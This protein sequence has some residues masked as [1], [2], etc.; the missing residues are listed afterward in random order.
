VTPLTP[1][2]EQALLDLSGVC[3]IY[4]N[5][6]AVVRAL[7]G[8]SL[9]VHAGEFVAIMGQSGSGKSTLMNIIGCL[10]RP[11]SGRYRVAGRDVSRLSPDELAALRSRMFG[12]VFQR[13]NLLGTATAVENVE[14]PGVYAGRRRRDRVVRATALLKRLGLGDRIGHR[15]SE[16]SG[17]QQQR[18]SIARALMN[19]AQIILADEPTGALDSKS[20]ED[21]L[22]LLHELHD[23]GRTIVLIT[24]DPAIAAH[25]ERVIQIRDGGIVSDT[26]AVLRP[27]ISVPRAPAS[28]GRHSAPLADIAEATKTA[29]RALRAN[30]FRT[31]LTLLGVVIGVAAVVV[32]LAIGNGS[33]QQVLDRI[34]AM[35]TNLLIVRPGAPGVRSSGDTATLVPADAE[36]IAALPNVEAAVPER[37][38]RIT[39]RVGNIDYQT[40]ILGTS[41]QYTNTRGWDVA[42]G[43]FITVDDVR[44]Y[45]PVIVLGQTVARNLF[46]DGDDPVGRYV[47]VRNVPMQVVGV[48]AP[49]G[50]TPFGNDQDDIAVVPLTTGFVQLFGHQYL[51]TVSVKVTDV[52]QIDQT[53]SAIDDLLQGRH[54]TLDFQVRNTASI[55]ATAQETQGTLTL[56]LAS[57]AAIS[58][59]VGGIGVMNIMLVN[60]TERRREIGIRMA[61][62]ARMRDILLQFNTEALVVC[63][64]G[65]L[66]GVVLGLGLAVAA[67]WVGF[68]VQ[69]SP[70]P[71]LLAFAC[72]FLTGLLFGF[73]P[74]HKAARLDPVVALASE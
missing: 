51:S 2:P 13:Y 25:A 48:L 32:M 3:K 6:E 10:D 16:L 15:P 69:L 53:E 30:L 34:S 39:L 29:F 21:L 26:G 44:G 20:G 1:K 17:G 47:L 9:R 42:A 56:L 60:V 55:L 12:F 58:L 73:L 46:P 68:P 71:A 61:T 4:H 63:G 27:P 38:G 23:S 74:A 31:L 22:G 18:V 14:I 36:A 57:V 5:G 37:N 19:D 52:D 8:A 54:R 45:A 40:T 35:G 59:L 65:G 67:G 49:K 7:D 28:T 72:A 24:H 62:G 11:T 64:V 33:Q 50:A 41:A 70:E 43:G 66:I